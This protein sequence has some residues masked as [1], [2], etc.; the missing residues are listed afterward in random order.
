MLNI[1]PN[2]I[3]RVKIKNWVE[4]KDDWHKKYDTNSQIRLNISVLRSSL[5]DYKDFYILAKGSITIT[6]EGVDDA[7]N[8]TSKREK[9]S[10]IKTF[11]DCISE[12]NNTQIEN[13]IIWMLLY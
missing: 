2:Q 5:C 6:R 7:A 11:T 4:V 13:A 12:I 1:I 9:R 10:N 8:R 3:S